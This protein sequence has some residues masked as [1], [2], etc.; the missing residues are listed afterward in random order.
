MTADSTECCE[1]LANQLEREC[2]D[3]AD[4]WG[5]PDALVVRHG[6]VVGMPIRDGGSSML[7]ISHCPWCGSQLDGDKPGQLE[8]GWLADWF[9]AQC[10][11]D[12]EHEFGVVIQTLDNP[13]WTIRIGI[14]ESAAEGRLLDF[15]DDADSQWVHLKSDGLILQGACHSDAVGAMLRATREFLQA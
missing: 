4:L 2:A 6:S 3:H 9:A 15:V 13:G 1:M 7:E 10:N 12:W 8:L 5:C 14:E 11:E